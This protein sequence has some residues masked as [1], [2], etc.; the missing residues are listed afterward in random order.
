MNI[1]TFAFPSA[2]V[3]GLRKVAAFRLRPAVVQVARVVHT[4]VVVMARVSLGYPRLNSV[5][6]INTLNDVTKLLNILILLNDALELIADAVSN[7]HR[8][9][10]CRVY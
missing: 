5:V 8:I 7:F 6:I 3:S 1:P 10:I 9:R 4:T 2:L